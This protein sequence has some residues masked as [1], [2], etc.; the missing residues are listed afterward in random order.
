MLLSSLV[1]PNAPTQVGECRFTDLR[2]V[3]DMNRQEVETRIARLQ[4]GKQHAAGLGRPLPGGVVEYRHGACV[5][6]VT[7]RQDNSAHWAQHRGEQ[8]PAP[9]TLQQKVEHCEIIKGEAPAA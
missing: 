3:P 5:M 1:A 2:I 6:R 7:Y 9:D 8:Q 4:G